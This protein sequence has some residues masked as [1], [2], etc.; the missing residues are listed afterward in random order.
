M[1]HQARPTTPKQRLSLLRGEPSPHAATPEP[2]TA[3]L[4]PPGLDYPMLLS[5]ATRNRGRVW[6]DTEN[7]PFNGE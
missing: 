1:R 5:W 2:L 6:T 4:T 7:T 3:Q